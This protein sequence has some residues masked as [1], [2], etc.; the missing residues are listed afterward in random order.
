MDS[1]QYILI[2]TIKSKIN[3]LFKII[4]I[5]KQRDKT[6]ESEI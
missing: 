3:A 4:I 6:G 5:I 2:L 1:D